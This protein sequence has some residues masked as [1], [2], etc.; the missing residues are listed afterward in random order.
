[1]NRVALLVI[2][3]LVVLLGTGVTLIF[4]QKKEYFEEADVI[5][6]FRDAETEK[7]LVGCM[8]TVESVRMFTD[9]KRERGSSGSAGDKTDAVGKIQRWDLSLRHYRITAD[10][11]GYDVQDVLVDIS[12]THKPR[13]WYKLDHT[14]AFPH[15]REKQIDDNQKPQQP[16]TGAPDG[17]AAESDHCQGRGARY[18]VHSARSADK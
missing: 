2:V 4:A 5:F 11:E 10:A 17:A 12:S 15:E 9:R 16:D 14:R 13:E 3:V 18:A 1:M 6:F 7:P 8:V